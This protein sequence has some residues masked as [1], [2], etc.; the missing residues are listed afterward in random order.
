ML[1]VRH[2]SRESL[3]APPPEDFVAL[4]EPRLVDHARARLP[5]FRALYRAL[6]SS[7]ADLPYR[8]STAE[9]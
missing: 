9:S 4:P 8:P 2:G 7:F 5:R 6:E 1:G 3:C